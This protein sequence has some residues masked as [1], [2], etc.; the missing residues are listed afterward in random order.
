LELYRN[1]FSR[2][3]EKLDLCFGWETEI[4]YIYVS[5]ARVF[6]EAIKLACLE[7]RA[8][9]A[10]Y[11]ELDTSNEEYNYDDDDSFKIEQVLESAEGILL[12]HGVDVAW[13]V[14][15]PES[16]SEPDPY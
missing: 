9:K 13:C 1:L 14:H 6:R 15:M 5:S 12:D 7:N 10:L 2:K 11:F 8:P 3:Y 4:H 16:P